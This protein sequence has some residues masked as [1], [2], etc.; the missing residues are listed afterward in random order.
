MTENRVF[1][2]DVSALQKY[3]EEH[4]TILSKIA[5]ELK[6]KEEV[7]LKQKAEQAAKAEKEAKE[8]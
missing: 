2:N 7:E 4:G 8:R 6:E 1:K 3:I 5:K